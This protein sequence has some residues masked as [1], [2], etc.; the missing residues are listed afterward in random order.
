M[1]SLARPWSRVK[2]SSVEW[3]R[4]LLLITTTHES[5]DSKIRTTVAWKPEQISS[6]NA[7]RL[8][9]SLPISNDSNRIPLT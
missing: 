3:N 6:L 8:P 7:G 2:G 5:L 9:A 1:I 4:D